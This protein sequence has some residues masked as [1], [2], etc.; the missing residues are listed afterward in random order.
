MS[1]KATNGNDA[2]GVRDVTWKQPGGREQAPATQASK[3]D[4]GDIAASNVMLD[5]SGAESVKAERVTMDRSGTKSLETKSAQLDQ[6]GAVTISAENV[7][8]LKSSAVQVVA[9][10]AR[11]KD[12]AVVL[13][14]ADHATVED[15]RIF[16]FAGTAEGP[17]NAALTPVTAAALGGAF[18]AVLAVLLLI[19]KSRSR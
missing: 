2:A 15:S 18:G 14:T 6:S 11:V 17:V 12:S 9:D 7:V 5:R 19:F 13:L 4:V 10:E 16:L 8:L 1:N 3:T